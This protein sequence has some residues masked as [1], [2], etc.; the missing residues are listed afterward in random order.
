MN[1]M[2]EDLDRAW[3]R[4]LADTPMQRY[5]VPEDRQREY[6]NR[7]SRNY[8]ERSDDISKGYS[9]LLRRLRESG[10]VRS[11]DDVLD[12]GSGTGLFSLPM[13]KVVSTLT[14]LERSEDMIEALSRKKNGTDNISLIKGDWN[15][16]VPSCKYDLVFSSFC[17]AVYN[18]RS[19]LRMEACSKRDCC[20]VAMHDGTEP[21]FPH[22][23]L[24]R[25]T[26]DIFDGSGLSLTYA[27]RMLT[28]MG[29]E[30]DMEV[31]SIRSSMESPAED[32][33]NRYMEYFSL[34]MSM[35]KTRSKVLREV[36]DEHTSADGMFEFTVQKKIAA[37]HWHVPR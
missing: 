9:E 36:I 18:L 21:Y 5:S 37:L 26:G 31:A 2:V 32:V 24:T 22:M 27:T 15:N 34:L 1:K 11:S 10:T 4:A 7:A 13:S 35:D 12:I 28:A 16:F 19:M 23:A 30:W 17:P 20:I 6:W 3:A 25:V 8:D 29:R 33:L 14:A